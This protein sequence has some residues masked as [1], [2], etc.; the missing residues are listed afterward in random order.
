MRASAL[1]AYLLTGVN[2]AVGAASHPRDNIRSNGTVSHN[3]QQACA[4][5]SEAFGSA[6]H[7]GDTDNFTI[8]DAKQ[9]EVH[10]ACRV[11]P[12]DASDVAKILEILLSNWCYFSVKGGGHSRNPG[13]SNSIGGVTVDLDRIRNIEI[14][15]DGSRARVG[16]GATTFQVY[17]ALESRNLS[18]VGGRVGTV[19]IGGFTLGGGTSPFSNKY[20]WA[21]DNVYE[22]EVVLANGT[23]TTASGSRNSDLYFALRGGGNNF[24]IV[25]AFTVRTFA[26]GAVFTSTSTYSN[27][28]TG[29]V[30]DRVYDLYTAENLTSDVEM[31]YDLYYT[32]N[33]ENDN[34]T[35]AGTQRYGK[36]IQSPS[37]FHSIDQIPPLTR[38]TTISTMSSLVNDPGPL[39]TVRHLFATLTVLPSRSLLTRGIQIFRQEVEAIKDVQ[40]LVPNFICY[41]I[42]RNAIVAMKQNGGNALGI[43]HA[44]PLFIILISTAWSNERDD[45]A[46][47]RMTG[48]IIRRLQAV[49]RDTGVGHRYIYIN[50]A[51]AAQV[52]DVFAGY[53][54]DNAQRLRDIQRAVDPQ[55]IFTSHGLWRGFVKLQ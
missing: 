37:I 38:T 13:D 11:E 53:G 10:P 52:H 22:Y 6:L 23:I 46:V 45:A 2:V 28:Q 17:Q 18:F 35:L 49:A 33:S 16:G 4:Q 8:W 24:G 19:G 12:S 1:F 15:E 54:E 44:G 20:G 39:G 3:C 41:P 40:G 31:G 48:N 29:P 5:L 14:S 34:F 27:N 25:T 30:L 21:L 36:P 7:Y 43:E 32:Y 9:Q 51:S 55:G 50:Y 26:Q 47:E 42:Q